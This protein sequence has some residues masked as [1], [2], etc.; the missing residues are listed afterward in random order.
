MTVGWDWDRAQLTLSIALAGL[1]IPTTPPGNIEARVQS[2]YLL[3]QPV[4]A[5]HGAAHTSSGR[6][7]PS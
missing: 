3:D 7:S 5:D 1:P 2:V 4:T 6:S